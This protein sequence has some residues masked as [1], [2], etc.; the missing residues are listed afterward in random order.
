MKETP[1]Q[2]VITGILKGKWDHE[3]AMFSLPPLMTLVSKL[4][5]F[6]VLVTVYLSGCVSV[7]QCNIDLKVHT[8]FDLCEFRIIMVSRKV[9]SSCTVA[10]GD[11]SFGVKQTDH[12]WNVAFR[13]V[14]VLKSVQMHSAIIQLV[15]TSTRILT[16]RPT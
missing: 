9:I 4:K 16:Q 15:Y 14:W 12:P 11:N 8:E 2:E 5:P 1:L 6:N 3:R 7:I 10:C 13:C